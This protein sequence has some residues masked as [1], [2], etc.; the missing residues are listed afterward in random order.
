MHTDPLNTRAHIHDLRL[1]KVQRFATAVAE[2]YALIANRY[3]SRVASHRQA[4][5]VQ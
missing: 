5:P 1:P 4:N 2:H 3:A